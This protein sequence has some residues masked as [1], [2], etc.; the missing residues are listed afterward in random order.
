VA[1]SPA[2]WSTA[3]V[4]RHPPPFLQE[5]HFQGKD[6]ARP[7]QHGIAS[8]KVPPLVV[9]AVTSC[10]V[11]ATKAVSTYKRQMSVRDAVFGG[12]YCL[13]VDNSFLLIIIFIL[14]SVSATFA[15]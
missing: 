15:I 7:A 5:Q 9:A 14:T 6:S 8:S 3:A 2:N 12:F 1:E 13:R 4:A 10:I 11:R